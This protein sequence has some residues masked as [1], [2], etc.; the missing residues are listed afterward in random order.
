MRDL[1][2]LRWLLE[3]PA[4]IRYLLGYR[5]GARAVEYH[6]C[7]V[8]ERPTRFARGKGQVKK[9]ITNYTSK[10]AVMEINLHEEG[11]IDALLDSVN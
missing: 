7:I 11:Y 9:T 3:G 10:M 6:A 4:E 2:S 5:E 1:Q 8:N